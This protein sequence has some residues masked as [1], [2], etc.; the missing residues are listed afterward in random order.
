MSLLSQRDFKIEH[1]NGE[2]RKNESFGRERK[3]E[4]ERERE[5]GREKESERDNGYHE[6]RK[7]N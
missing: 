7:F 6:L 3:R 4:R 2:R 5:R 1:E